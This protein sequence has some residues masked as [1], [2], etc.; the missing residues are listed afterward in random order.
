MAFSV[1]VF[2]RM[3]L[4]KYW[5]R[6]LAKRGLEGKALER[7]YGWVVFVAPLGLGDDP[8][9]CGRA[10]FLDDAIRDA[11]AEHQRN[12]RYD[13]AEALGW[14]KNSRRTTRSP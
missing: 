6:W 10:G 4:R 9:A 3:Q 13:V 11:Y 12:P 8:T 14:L 5:V 2:S 1:Q 7:S